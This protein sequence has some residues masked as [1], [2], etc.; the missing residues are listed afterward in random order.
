MCAHGC[1]H[2]GVV[3]DHRIPEQLPGEPLGAYLLLHT[4]AR[5]VAAGA[6]EPLEWIADIHGRTPGAIAATASAWRW[7]ERLPGWTELVTPPVGS[8]DGAP[9]TRMR[10][11]RPALTR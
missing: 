11:N 7:R 4:A 8:R 2:P 1:V 9:R 10:V 6:V 5:A 3:A